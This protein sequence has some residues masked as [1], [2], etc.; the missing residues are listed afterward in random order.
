MTGP[1]NAKEGLFGA[2]RAKAFIDAVVA[3]AMTLLILPLM[4]SVAEASAKGENAGAWVTGHT[5][6]LFA[7]VLSFAII[8]MFW[9]NHHRVFT[10]VERVST[11][12]L[13]IT[14]GWL[15]SI[16]WLPVV[17]AM[18]GQMPSTDR[19]LISM[20]IGSMILTTVLGLATILYLRAHPSMHD[21]SRDRVLRWIA[22]DLAMIALFAVSLLVA[23]LVPVVSYFALFLMLFTRPV[24]VMFARAIGAG[25]AKPEDAATDD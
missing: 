3:I 18:V 6:Q 14:M 5:D 25:R 13:W 1:V 2:E 21:I 4:E 16:V 19:V 22:V 24:Q 9:I 10:L 20:Y 11:A 7:F 12:L 15:L 23:V 17:T 8:A